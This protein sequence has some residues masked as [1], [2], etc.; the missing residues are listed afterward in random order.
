MQFTFPDNFRIVTKSKITEHQAALKILSDELDTENPPVLWP[1]CKFACKK[2]E[3]FEFHTIADGNKPIIEKT[4]ALKNSLS[5]RHITTKKFHGF[6]LSS[7]ESYPNFPCG[8]KLFLKNSE[9]NH[10]KWLP[11]HVLSFK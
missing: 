4:E 5:H 7:D 6:D 11:D 1:K 3:L 9:K 2:T 8:Q 10:I